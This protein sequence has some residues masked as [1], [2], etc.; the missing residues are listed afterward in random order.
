[1]KINKLLPLVILL[2]ICMTACDTRNRKAEDTID[3]DKAVEDTFT[4]FFPESTPDVDVEVSE[5]DPCMQWLDIENNP[6]KGN[7]PNSSIKIIDIDCADFDTTKV[8][9]DQDMFDKPDLT[10]VKT[11]DI[12]SLSVDSG[13]IELKDCLADHDGF[14]KYDYMGYMDSMNKYFVSCTGWEVYFWMTID[15][16]TGK[17]ENIG[18]DPLLSA[19][20]T[21]LF[22]YSYNPYGDVDTCELNLY[23]IKDGNLDLIFSQNVER[24]NPNRLYWSNDSIF[25]EGTSY[26]DIDGYH[27]ANCKVIVLNN[28]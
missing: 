24:L 8:S 23:A 21:Q 19:D 25:I 17:M 9:V 12:L 22:T 11:N 5:E 20:K 28:R 14:K 10:I 18:Y 3:I 15:K 26:S 13:I 4:Q 16:K 6:N 1:M 27:A 2:T 7:T